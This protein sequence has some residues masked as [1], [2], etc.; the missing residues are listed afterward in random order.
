V[1][2][3]LFRE[4][5]QLQSYH[6]WFV[7]RRRVLQAV[8]DQLTLPKASQVLEIGCGT[9]G[10]LVFL[11]R[12]GQLE[13]IEFD[14][15]AREYAAGLKVCP[16]HPGGLPDP[17]PFD[18]PQFD[19]ICMF[20]VLE[21]ISDDRL[22][23]IKAASLLRIGGWLVVSVPAYQWLWSA[24]DTAHHHYRRYTRGRLKELANESG[25][26][27]VR[28]GYFNS[29]LFPF[30][31][32]VRVF[33]RLS[34]ARVDASSSGSDTSMPNALINWVLRWIFGLEG[35]LAKHSLFPFGTSALVVLRRSSG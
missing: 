16:V 11:S 7:A 34:T 25:L 8:L 14:P 15:I 10:N 12:Y 24:H 23:I 27:V 3:D 1:T 22:A 35:F 6:W 31:V 21:H 9:G 17:I 18:S 32:G 30:A 33:R 26:T 13:A 29:I 19:L 2:P 4:M 5:A 28:A 20:D